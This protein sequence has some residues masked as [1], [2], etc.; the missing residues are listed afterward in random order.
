M[1]VGVTLVLV[2]NVLV[3]EVMVRVCL[4]LRLGVT[5]RG[6]SSV[7]DSSLPSSVIVA[8]ESWV[9]TWVWS[10]GGRRWNR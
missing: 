4:E 9:M 5:A 10:R 7:K 6:L 1:E 8:S 3:G 2:R